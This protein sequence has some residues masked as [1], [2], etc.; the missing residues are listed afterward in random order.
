[1]LDQ[2]DADTG[3][4]DPLMCDVQCC[5]AD[6]CV[7]FPWGVDYYFQRGANLGT[8]EP[9]LLEDFGPQM[10]V[11]LTML[12]GKNKNSV[13]AIEVVQQAMVTAQG[14]ADGIEAVKYRYQLRK[15]AGG[16]KPVD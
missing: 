5:A 16:F 14:R 15:T 3:K 13:R 9:S 12:A 8:Y 11:E 10:N 1:M 6:G 7:D 4:V 2:F